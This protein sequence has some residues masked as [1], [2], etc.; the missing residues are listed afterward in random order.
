MS[1]ECDTVQLVHTNVSQEYALSIFRVGAVD[2]SKALLMSSKTARCHDTN[3]SN[4]Q[5]G[6]AMAQAV[7]RRPLTAKAR[8]RSRVGPCGISGQS[9]T[10][11]GSSPR[12]LRFSPVNFIPP[13]LDYKEK[14]KRNYSSSSQS[15]TISLKAA[16][17]P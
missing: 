5:H 11:T 1:A 3:D 9:G 17:R 8:I 6:R 14:R 13:M 16:V 15:C 4:C 7:S 12:V 2:S 10:R